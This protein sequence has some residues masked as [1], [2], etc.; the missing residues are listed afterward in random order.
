[1]NANVNE[2]TKELEIYCKQKGIDKVGFADLTH[3]KVFLASHGDAVVMGY[4]RA[5]S[6]GMRINDAIVDNHDPDEPRGKSLYWH[7]IYDVVSVSLNFVAYDVSRWLANKG[8]NSLPVPASMPYNL[9]TLQGVISHK[10]T[11]HLAGIGWI[12]KSC[13]LLT[14]EFGPRVSF[15]TVLTDAPLSVGIKK[16][17]KCGKCTSCIDACPIG[18]LKDVEFSVEDDVEARFDTAR[19]SEYRGKHPCGLCV[20]SCPVGKNVKRR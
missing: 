8:W 20:S 2:F 12:G 1:M 19:C 4:P 6:I 11:A 18:A 5:V 15:T 13:L 17:K 14:P 7:H 3:A 9:K 10:L 16:D